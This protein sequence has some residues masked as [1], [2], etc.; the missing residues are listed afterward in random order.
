MEKQNEKEKQKQKQNRSKRKA[1]WVAVLVTLLGSVGIIFRDSVSHLINRKI[2]KHLDEP[3]KNLQFPGKELESPSVPDDNDLS[4]FNPFYAVW[5]QRTGYLGK[6]LSAEEMKMPS[7]KGLTPLQK[8]LLE[9]FAKAAT[10]SDYDEIIGLAHRKEY[11]LDSKLEESLVA[12]ASMASQKSKSSLWTN[13]VPKLDQEKIGP[14]IKLAASLDVFA[15]LPNQAAQWA[16]SAEKELVSYRNAKAIAKCIRAAAESWVKNDRTYATTANEEFFASTDLTLESKVIFGFQVLGA[17]ASKTSDPEGAKVLLKKVKFIEEGLDSLE[18]GAK[19]SKYVNTRMRMLTMK[20]RLMDVSKEVGDE[21]LKDVESDLL[22]LDTTNRNLPNLFYEF[23]NGAVRARHPVSSE[24][25]MRFEA[26]AGN[27]S[28]G[29]DF[30]N[31]HLALLEEAKSL[32]NRR[33]EPINLKEAVEHCNKAINYAS[34][35]KLP[36]AVTL[37]NNLKNVLQAIIKKQTK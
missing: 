35:S 12:F 26:S 30:R 33:I 31:Y 20:L 6:S 32:I 28:Q 16:K 8:S 22:V 11:G 27:T 34:S 19:T 10:V 21:D 15:E 14:F 23:V 29:S 37:T 4:D 5:L 2:D 7:L 9:K 3:Q 36:E 25:M 24:I 17:M 18:T 13:L 1:T